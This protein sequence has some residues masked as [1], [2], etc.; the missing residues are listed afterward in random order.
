V[1]VGR[2]KVSEAYN[3]TDAT[4]G[5]DVSALMNRELNVEILSGLYHWKLAYRRFVRHG[6]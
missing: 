4:G 5:I 1:A 6:L 3:I 2:K